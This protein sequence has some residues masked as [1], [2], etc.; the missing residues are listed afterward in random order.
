MLIDLKNLT[1]K[2]AREMIHN[3]EISCRKLVA[4]YGEEIK[5]K[6]QYINGYLEIFDD[7]YETAEKEDERV[8]SGGEPKV[9][10]GIPFAVKDNILIKGKIASA[11]S[12]ILENYKAPYDATVIKKLR[13]AGAVLMGRTNMDEFAMGSSTENS[14]FGVVGNPYDLERVAEI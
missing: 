14:A 7:A 8:K 10:S 5:K 4:I 11:G 12:K 9:L 3:G 6:N 13:L 1:I 2:K